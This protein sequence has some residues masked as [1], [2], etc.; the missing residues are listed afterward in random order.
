M[1]KQELIAE[2]KELKKLKDPESEHIHAD[3]LLLKFI[4]DDDITKA[5]EDI[6]KRYS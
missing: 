1:E 6:D 5:F 4:N 3:E 2:L